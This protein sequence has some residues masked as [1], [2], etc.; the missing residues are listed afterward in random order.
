M[1]EEFVPTENYTRLLE[2]ITK[3]KALPGTAPRMGLGHGNFGLGK[4]MS[5]ERVAALENALPFRAAQ[6]W[7]RTGLLKLLCEELGLDT[8]GSTHDKYQRVVSSLNLEPRVLIVDEIDALFRSDKFTVLE[9]LRDIHDETPA[10]LF[11]I[12]MEEADAKLKRHRHFYSRVVEFVPFLPTGK[13]DVASFC[14]LCDVT[15]KDDVV[16]HLAAR[17]PNLRQIKV[18]LLRLESW[19]EINGVSEVDMKTWQKSGVERGTKQI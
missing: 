14:R 18:M 17:Y 10:V 7:T 12:G 5:I 6:T 4:T 2:A 19:C 1:K 15:V 8:Q 3:L 9:L 16:E 13:N 11:M